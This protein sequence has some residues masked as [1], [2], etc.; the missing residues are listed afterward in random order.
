MVVAEFESGSILMKKQ[1]TS[2]TWLAAQELLFWRLLGNWFVDHTFD[3]KTRHLTDFALASKTK[4]LPPHNTHCMPVCVPT[5]HLSLWTIYLTCVSLVISLHWEAFIVT[6][7]AVKNSN[8]VSDWNFRGGTWWLFVAPVLEIMLKRHIFVLSD[9]ST[10][11]FLLA[12]Q[13][14]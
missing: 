7:S 9:F 8:E 4:S 5:I 13:T 1:M 11:L 12:N 14:H 6:C 3:Y 2:L 10:H